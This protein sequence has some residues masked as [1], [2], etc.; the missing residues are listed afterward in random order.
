MQDKAW[1]AAVDVVV[2]VCLSL[3]LWQ[4]KVPTEAFLSLVTAMVVAREVGRKSDKSAGGGIP[5]GATSG[6][7]LLG[8]LL[9]SLASRGRVS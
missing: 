2:V 8:G 9:L 5:P 6:F 3:L 7:L 4:D 1:I